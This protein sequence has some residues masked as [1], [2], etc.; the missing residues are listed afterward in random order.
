MMSDFDGIGF[1]ELL[2]GVILVLLFVYG[3]TDIEGL[4]STPTTS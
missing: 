2:I 4:S 1:A 3:S